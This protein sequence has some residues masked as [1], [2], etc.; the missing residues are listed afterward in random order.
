MGR[1]LADEAD[2][3]G[4]QGGAGFFSLKND[5]D[6]AKVR[7]M[8]DS[9]DDVEGYAVHEIEINGKKRYVDCKRSYNEPVDNCP[10]CKKGMPQ[11]AK[12]FVPI[13]DINSGTVKIWE[14]GKKFFNQI[15]Q[16]C[17]RYAQNEPLCSHIFEIERSGKAGDQGTTYGIYET[18]K[19]NTT[20]E[21]LPELPKIIG[22]LVLDKTPEDMEYFDKHGDFPDDGGEV[23]FRRRDAEPEQRRTPSRGDRF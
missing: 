15:S 9:I 5:K 3:Y 16:L 20:L 11:K 23:P 17:S 10:F 6:V 14:R 4:G 12:L 1:F 13:Y 22:G 21:D 18:G 19:D 2:N 8:Y 7:F